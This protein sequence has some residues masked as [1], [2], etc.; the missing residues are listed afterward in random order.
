MLVISLLDSSVGRALDYMAKN[1]SLVAVKTGFI[2][3]L[4]PTLFN[5]L[6]DIVQDCYTQFSLNSIV[7]MFLFNP[8]IL[9][10]PWIWRENQRGAPIGFSYSE[11]KF[12]NKNIVKCPNLNA[13]IRQSIYFF[14][15]FF[16][17]AVPSKGVNWDTWCELGQN[18]VNRHRCDCR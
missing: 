7:P 3:V 18:L 8:V 4:L 6:H 10:N 16:C 5:F 9:T 14:Q 17:F 15:F 11:I 13:I 2:N 1:R 12:L